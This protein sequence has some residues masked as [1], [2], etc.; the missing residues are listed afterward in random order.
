V[1]QFYWVS[2]FEAAGYVGCENSF[3]MTQSWTTQVWVL[4]PSACV[5]PFDPYTIWQEQADLAAR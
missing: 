5:T 1:A 4:D 2:A 3:G